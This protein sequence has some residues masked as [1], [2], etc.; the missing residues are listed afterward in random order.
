MKE[1]YY[2]VFEENECNLQKLTRTD[3]TI[4]QSKAPGACTSHATELYGQIQSGELMGAINGRYKDGIWNRLR[5][6]T[7]DRLVPS[8]HDFFENLKYLKG[9][10]ECMKRLV[11]P[12]SDSIRSALEKKFT[13]SQNPVG[14]CLIQSSSQS[15]VRTVGEEY[16]RFDLLYKQLWLFAIREYREVPKK[17]NQRLAG[18]KVREANQITLYNFAALAARFGFLTESVEQILENDPDIE[19]ARRFV[20]TVRRPEQHCSRSLEE[21]TRG[22]ADAIRK[23]VPEVTAED[24]CQPLALSGTSPMMC[25][26]PSDL[27]QTRDRCLMFLPKLND[28]SDESSMF[29]TSFFVQRSIFFS[30]FG[31]E[32]GLA[33][34]DQYQPD[35]N[36][37]PTT[38]EPS[39]DEPTDQNMSN[40]GPNSP[41]MENADHGATRTETTLEDLATKQEKLRSYRED[42]ERLEQIIVHLRNEEQDLQ[43][44][45]KSLSTAAQDRKQ[46]IDRCEARVEKLISLGTTMEEAVRTQNLSMSS[47]KASKI[48]EIKELEQRLE[49]V[50][51]RIAQSAANEEKKSQ[52]VVELEAKLDWLTKCVEEKSQT[53]RDREAYALALDQNVE[54]RLTRLNEI[55]E[56]IKEVNAE[57]TI[58][59]Q[60]LEM[61]EENLKAKE[62]RVTKLTKEVEV[63]ES[64]IVQ[65]KE[66]SKTL[67]GLDARFKNTAE[68]KQKQTSQIIQVSLLQPS[69]TITLN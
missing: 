51:E 33:N 60:Q 68:I 44:A 36:S 19:M 7:R 15:F 24:M 13:E 45:I 64:T 29:L 31:K 26:V 9:P 22:V 49:L 10:A 56:K 6:H 48:R 37:A 11:S 50:D 12:N 20:E 3:I 4:L 28:A 30:F 43:A 58:K 40:Q 23:A 8:L 41:A 21:C 59:S 42:E 1:F 65:V 2:Y 47:E 63:I 57:E 67:D 27:D 16:N 69:K 35:D 55:E 5:S 66:K 14:S 32:P 52:D 61:T 38:D 54:E 25:G 46:E 53:I 17:L 39:R 34:E 62:A 18:P